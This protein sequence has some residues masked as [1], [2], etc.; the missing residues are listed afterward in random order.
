MLI[1]NKRC[2]ELLFVPHLRTSAGKPERTARSAEFS[3]EFPI[4]SPVAF[5][6]SWCKHGYIF[7]QV[8]LFFIFLLANGLLIRPLKIMGAFY[9][10]QRFWKNFP[11]LKNT[12]WNE[13]VCL[14]E[15]N[16]I[17]S[18]DKSPSLLLGA[19]KPA[20]DIISLPL[21]CASVCRFTW[22]T[23]PGFCLR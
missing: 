13:M 21:F 17:K 5:K 1:Y 8:L 20:S 18:L 14:N 23:M 10:Q 11:V 4:Q 12:C 15:I 3:W 2:K 19:C 6:N 7:H 16:I 9:W 22:G